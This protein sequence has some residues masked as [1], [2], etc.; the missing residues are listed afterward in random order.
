MPDA[1]DRLLATSAAY[2]LVMEKTR[3][4]GRVNLASVHDAAKGEGRPTARSWLRSHLE[5]LGVHVLVCGETILVDRLGALA[6]MVE[7]DPDVLAAYAE[8]EAARMLA[9]PEVVAAM[10]EGRF[11]V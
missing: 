8:L 3:R 6:Y 9:S 10:A 11:A 4:G 2:R 7:N 1:L 5:R